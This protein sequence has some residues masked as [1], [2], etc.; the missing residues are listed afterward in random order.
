[1]LFS[2]ARRALRAASREV[3]TLSSVPPGAPPLLGAAA[4]ADGTWSSQG[5]SSESSRGRCSSLRAC[6]S[7]QQHSQRRRAWSAPETQSASAAHS[8]LVPAAQSIK[9]LYINY[10]CLGLVPFRLMS[11]T[12]KPSDG[13]LAGKILMSDDLG[14]VPQ[15]LEMRRRRGPTC[16]S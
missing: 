5:S 16:C 14:N 3:T 10:S 7:R 12:S 9:S 6:G 15:I 4:A 13:E 8:A 1:M 2:A 11:G